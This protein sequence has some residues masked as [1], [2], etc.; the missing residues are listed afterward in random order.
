MRSKVFAVLLILFVGNCD[1]KSN[2]NFNQLDGIWI[3]KINSGLE[4]FDPNSFSGQYL[5]FFPNND[6]IIVWNASGDYSQKYLF[7]RFYF[8]KN[9]ANLFSK[10]PQQGIQ[11]F[12]IQFTDN[13]TLRVIKPKSFSETWPESYYIRAPI[14][15]SENSYKDMYNFFKKDA[16][17]TN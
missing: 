8:E 3:H 13:D 16:S 1:Q 6:K 12:Q 4:R 14:D 15:D 9:T 5:I 11:E 7:D 2:R 10:N 17:S